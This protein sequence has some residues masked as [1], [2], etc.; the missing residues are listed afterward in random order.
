MLLTQWY[1]NMYKTDAFSIK[2][3]Y[4]IAVNLS[5][6]IRPGTGC[7]CAFKNDKGNGAKQWKLLKNPRQC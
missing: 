1:K 5:V 7:K 4:D 3:V 2:L 6:L